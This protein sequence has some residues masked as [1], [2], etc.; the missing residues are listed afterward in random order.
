MLD[1]FFPAHNS[2]RRPPETPTTAWLALL[3]TALAVDASG[4]AAQTCT[5]CEARVLSSVEL[6]IPEAEG[7]SFGAPMDFTI[8][9]SGL[10]WLIQSGQLPVVFSPDGRFLGRFGS[11]GEGPREFRHPV[12]VFNVPGDS[13]AIVDAGNRRVT[14][15]GPGRVVGR[16]V[17]M[18]YT[19]YRAEVVRWPDLI[20][21]SSV[22]PTPERAGWPLHFV[23]LSGSEM[24]V[25][26]S[27]GST[28]TVMS[29]S[30]K[31]NLRIRRRLSR[32]GPHFW[33]VDEYKLHARRWSG[34]GDLLEERSTYLEWFG[35]PL[36]IESNVPEA[37]DGLHYDSETGLLWIVAS[38]VD[39]SVIQ[40]VIERAQASGRQEIPGSEM[41]PVSSYRSSRLL[42]LDA[43]SQLRADV[44][45]DG[46][47]V[48][49]APDGTMLVARPG[50][51]EVV[52]L[53]LERIAL[54][55]DGG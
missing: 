36:D 38:D 14:I 45:I 2:V 49:V 41:P 50:P 10:I 54:G 40:A 39:R 24:G 31:D 11:I 21:V 47:V 48:S 35:E 7:G 29:G 42:A 15:V 25:S 18:S 32:A 23:D 26:A 5:A 9:E 3:V 33:A 51:L 8:D 55:L 34:S 30:L 4:V 27:F 1:R 19:I 53:Y 43:Q 17:R 13:V 16:T 6:L 20:M 37:V 52:R 44:P 12:T 22:I 46:Q 28:Q